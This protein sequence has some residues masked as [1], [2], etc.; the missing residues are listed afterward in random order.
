MYLNRNLH[1]KFMS[2]NDIQ[3]IHE[4]TLKVLDEIGIIFES[5]RALEVFKQHGARVDGETVYISEQL[6]HEALKT[7]PS[8]FE[9]FALDNSVKIGK[10]YEP[11]TVGNPA[12]FQIIHTDGSIKN[13]TLDDVVNFHKLAETSEVIRMSTSVG[14][15]TDDIDKTLDNMYM[16]YVALGLKYSSKPVYQA[17]AVT[18][19]N[20][21]NKDL[22]EAAREIAVFHKKF[23]D[24]WDKPVVL[25]NL[26]LLSPLAVGSEVLANMFGLIEENQPVIFI[27]CGMTNLT[28][29]PTLMGSIIQSNATLLAAIVLTQLV[30][31]GVPAMFGSVSGPT[32][33]RTLQLAVGAPESM[34][35]QMGLLA[36]G[37]FYNLPIRTGVGVSSALDADYQAGAETMM[38]LTTGLVGKSDF[39]LNTAGPLATYNMGSYEK[40]V[41]DE[42]TAS[43]L[44]RV[45]QGIMISDKKACFDLMKKVGPRGD[46]LK[47]RTSR[48]YREEHY[49]PKIFNRHG[50]N[51]TVLI[52]QNGTLRD[53][54]GREVKE[55]L[56]AYQLPETTKTQQ[57][58]LNEYLPPQFRY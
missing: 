38:M 35:I 41:L 53:R 32:D 36:M 34:L 48:D 18:P 17:N 23:F 27:D 8:E 16:P 4:Y 57:N 31:P 15:D 24:I 58:L 3:M 37:R 33:M 13:T 7:A 26:A 29:P 20:W 39:I 50:G 10:R 2:P 19:L 47:G 9:L 21:K 52:E 56:E 6:L 54:A 40:Y 28:S 43:Y 11:V 30:N 55:R 44:K 46:Y 22:T 49:L 45:N 25:S 5:E 42:I 1:E 12:H 14:Y 51:S